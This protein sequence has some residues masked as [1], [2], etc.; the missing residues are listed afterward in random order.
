MKNLSQKLL[1]C[2]LKQRFKTTKYTMRS[3]IITV[4]NITTKKSLNLFN[5]ITIADCLLKQ[6]K[7]IFPL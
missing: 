2:I 1:S 3:K 4:T 5:R 7:I 6:S